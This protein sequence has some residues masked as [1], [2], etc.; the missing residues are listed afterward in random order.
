MAYKVTISDSANHDLDE[1]LTYISKTLANPKAA[2]DFAAEL[3]EKYTE[4][5]T[6]PF[7]FEISRNARLAQRGYRRFVIGSY[8]ALYLVNEEQHEIYSLTGK[9]IT[10]FAVF[11]AV[12]LRYRHLA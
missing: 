3:E 7:L 2:A 9:S 1:I 5:E 11:L 8:V 10:A 4:L 12:L 6:H